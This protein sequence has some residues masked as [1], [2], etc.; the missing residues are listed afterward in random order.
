MASLLVD[1]GN[2]TQQGV[3][4]VPPPFLS[5]GLVAV[6]SGAFVGQSVF[7]GNADTFCNLQLQGVAASGRLRVAVQC[8]DTDT[9]G[10]FTDP[11]SGLAQMPT[12][13]SSGGVL[14]VNSGLD[15]GTLGALVS[16]QCIASGFSVAGGFQRTGTFVRAVA[17]NEGSVQFGG[18]LTAVFVSQLRSPGSGG[19]FSYSPSSGV[20]NV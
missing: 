3:S 15:N 19:G 4:I 7:M 9:S 2:T 18:T 11:T 1:L 16:G 8:S 20:V 14:L 10:S 5:G 13:F 6:A 12:V 17:L